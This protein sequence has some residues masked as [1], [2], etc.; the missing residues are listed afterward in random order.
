MIQEATSEYAKT[1][2]YDWLKTVLKEEPFNLFVG[3]KNHKVDEEKQKAIS[4]A[5]KLITEMQ[6]FIKR[7]DR[8]AIVAS[9]FIT[10][11]AHARLGLLNVIPT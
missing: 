11:L 5:I 10:R 6:M 9:K 1:N 8:I 7:D 3:L 4:D 2:R